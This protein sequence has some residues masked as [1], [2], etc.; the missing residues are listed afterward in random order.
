VPDHALPHTAGDEVA[1]PSAAE[2]AAARAAVAA[3]TDDQ[4]TLLKRLQTTSDDLSAARIQ[5]LALGTK[6][7]AAQARV[8][9]TKADEQR[10]ETDVSTA[11]RALGL[12][13]DHVAKLAAAT[14]Y[15]LS[16][17]VMLEA[18]NTSDRTEVNRVRTYAKAPEK[19]LDGLVAKAMATER[20]LADAR[21]RAA[22]A[23]AVAADALD[24]ARVALAK[25]RDALAA[26]EGANAAAVAAVTAA[27]GSN[28]ALLGQ[29]ADPHFGADAITAALAVAQAGQDDP[30]T[31]F[32]AF[33]LP[34]PG[35]PL[36]SPYGIRVDPLSGALGYHPGVDFEAAAGV[37]VHAAAPGVV[38]MAGDCGG[39]GNCV[40]IDHGHS[41]AT[42]SAHLSRI[43]V[44]V[45][46]PVADGDVV[47]LVG[48]TG[49]STGPHLHFEVRLHGAPIDPTAALSV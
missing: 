13:R 23:R 38:V 16:G 34:I 26:A 9:T 40:V 41:L 43:L 15:D 20:Q 35:A 5:A 7:D 46:A 1:V 4:R 48:S 32:G 33:R 6:V 14:Y 24:D 12:A 21:T 10:A 49:N 2:S 27:L 44:T 39:Y 18:V 3:L 47:G 45:G 36:G 42:V 11:I 37:E 17:A 28:V 25:Q 31:L 8:T 30:A 22:D 19:L 29:V